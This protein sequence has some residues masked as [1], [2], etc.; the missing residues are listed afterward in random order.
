MLT[1]PGMTQIPTID[2]L[3]KKLLADIQKEASVV[4]RPFAALVNRLDLDE[5]EVRP[6]CG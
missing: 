6:E 5:A 2:E 3:D 1:L 4:D